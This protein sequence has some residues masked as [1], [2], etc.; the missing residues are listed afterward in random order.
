MTST[1]SCCLKCL[2]LIQVQCRVFG[3]PSASLPRTKIE[4]ITAYKSMTINKCQLHDSMCLFDLCLRNYHAFSHSPTSLFTLQ[5]KHFLPK[6]NIGRV[7]VCVCVCVCVIQ[8]ASV[9]ETTGGHTVPPARG[10]HPLHRSCHCKPLC[11]HPTTS[12]G[13]HHNPAGRP[14]PCLQWWWAALT[15]MAACP[16]APTS[17]KHSP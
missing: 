6:Q 10:G 4:I 17:G 1:W 3:C 5:L 13:W 14:P 16:P 12:S 7:C 2:N 15:V 9:L 8:R 11:G